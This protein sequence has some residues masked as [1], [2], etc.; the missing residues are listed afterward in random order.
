MFR[1]KG[2]DANFLERERIKIRDMDR[3][4]LLEDWRTLQVGKLILVMRLA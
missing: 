4:R 2:Y 3:D 1:D